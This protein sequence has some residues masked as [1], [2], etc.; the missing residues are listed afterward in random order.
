MT[1][2]LRSKTMGLFRRFQSDEAGVTAILFAL[3]AIPALC[4]GLAALDYSRAYGWQGRLQDTADAAA[5]A[6]A[7][8]LGEASHGE[9]ESVILA[10]LGANL[11]TTGKTYSYAVSYGEGDSSVTL[12]LNDTVS[13][14]IMKLAGQAQLDVTAVS[15]AQRQTIVQDPKAR[16]RE[17]APD[18]EEAMSKIPIAIENA[19]DAREAERAV[20]QLI[21]ELAGGVS[22]TDA[23]QILQQ[24][25]QF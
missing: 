7:Q 23:R 1:G 20:R 9:I 19:E 5:T 22:E 11:P 8:K 24:L 21:Q 4:I 16:R 17:I 18:A 15:T 2:R 3:M 6:A 10:Y 14:G 25:G 13:T 12:R